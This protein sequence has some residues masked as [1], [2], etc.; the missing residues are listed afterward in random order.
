[1]TMAIVKM[2]QYKI[3]WSPKFQNERLAMAMTL[4]RYETLKKFLHVNDN[5]SRNNLDDPND[6]R[7][8]VRPLLDLVT[9]NCIKIEPEKSH[10]IDEQIMPA[11]TKRSRGVNLHNPKKF[12]NEVS[13]I[14]SIFDC[15][16]FF[17]V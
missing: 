2:S 15:V 11:K 17:Y 3:Y 4:K 5:N 16:R 12:I 9:N 13:R 1:M 10:S 7:F 6:K 14:L 8:K